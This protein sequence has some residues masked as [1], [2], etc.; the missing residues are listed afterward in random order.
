MKNIM[1][2]GWQWF[3]AHTKELIRII[4][5]AFCW[6]ILF[7]FF[8]TVGPIVEGKYIP[9]VADINV[10][11]VKPKKDY[12]EIIFEGTK[13]RTCEFIEVALLAGPK[14]Q[15]VKGRVVFEDYD[16][17]GSKTRAPGRQTFGP[18]KI[19]PPGTELVLVAYHRCHPLWQTVTPLVH[20]S[21]P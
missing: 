19:Y 13:V 17:G 8:F 12:T 6:M 1:L 18:W 3:K 4:A 10:T 14:G 5:V 9:V 7:F 15:L 2:T 16:G 21:A 11:Y 20:W